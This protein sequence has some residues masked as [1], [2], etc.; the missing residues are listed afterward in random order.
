VH[1]PRG[2]EDHR[3]SGT[4]GRWLPVVAYVALIFSLSSIPYL[5]PPLH[6]TDAD[7]LAHF[8]EYGG[9]GL[10]F[11][12]AWRGSRMARRGRHMIFLLTVLVGVTVG[13]LDEMNQGR[14]PGRT[15]SLADLATDLA[16]VT[17]AAGAVVAVDR[18]RGRG[19]GAREEG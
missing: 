14:V 5:T 15:R 1:P 17:V 9:L 12:R 18:R 6:V 3:L 4:W 19:K 8:V 2:I 13:A 11:A 7:K 10:L 16:A